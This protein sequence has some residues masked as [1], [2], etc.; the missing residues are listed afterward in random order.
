MSAR[1]RWT[2][3]ELPIGPTDLALVAEHADAVEWNADYTRRIVEAARNRELFG[4]DHPS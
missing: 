2:E 1:K 4:E 3:P